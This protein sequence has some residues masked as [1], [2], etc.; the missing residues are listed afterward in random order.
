MAPRLE[1]GAGRSRRR[2]RPR[3]RVRPRR[4]GPPGRQP[5]ASRALRRSADP[6]RSRDDPAPPGRHQPR[7]GGAPT[8]RPPR[9]AAVRGVRAAR[10]ALGRAGRAAPPGRRAR[11]LPG[12]SR[13]PGRGGLRRQR[14]GPGDPGD[15]DRRRGALD[16]RPD[17]ARF[18]P[19]SGWAAVGIHAALGAAAGAGAAGLLRPV[20]ADPAVQRPN[21]RHAPVAVIGGLALLV[22]VL[23]VVT[24]ASVAVALGRLGLG[25]DQLGRQLAL[26][27]VLG[28]GL[29]GL[30]DDLVGSGDRRGFGGHLRAVARGQAT[31][32][33]VKI[34]GGGLVALL[35]AALAGADD[36][37]ELVLDTLAI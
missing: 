31:T 29:V 10:A 15:D 20:L 6:R 4:P 19:V 37:V 35:L 26:L 7:G 12:R 36:V 1:A 2:R 9:P 13:R 3:G 30:L 23:A 25:D 33:A 22:A 34:V 21:Y 16:R 18:A 5:D 8:G 32:G 27:A 11:C 24:G 17:P 14:F 28:F